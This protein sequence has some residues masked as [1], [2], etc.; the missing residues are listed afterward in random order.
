LETSQLDAVEQA[1]AVAGSARLGLMLLRVQRRRQIQAHLGIVLSER[2][3]GLLCARLRGLLRPQDQVVAAA[4]DTDIVVLLPDLLSPGHAQMAAQR[5]LRE[6]DHPIE[7][8]GHSV[9]L[10]LTI[11]LALAPDHARAGD[12][13]ARAALLALD[14][15][16]RGGERFTMAVAGAATGLR[17]EDLRHALL[18]NELTMAFQPQLDLR[19]G[20]IVAVEALARWDHPELGG[21]APDQF[22]GLAERMGLSIEL[23]RWSLN[24]ALREHAQLR[25]QMPELACAI[26]LSPKIFGQSGLIEQVLGALR[27][28]DLPP[29]LLTVEVTETAVLED[30]DYSGW[31]LAQ[32]HAAGVDISIDDFG[33]GYSSFSYFKQFPARELKIDQLFVTQVEADPRDQQIIRSMIELAHNLGMRALAE[34]VENA[35]VLQLLTE[36]GCDRAQG[37]HIGRPKPVED[38]LEQWGQGT[39]ERVPGGVRAQGGGWCESG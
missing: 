34:G 3:Q 9:L 14:G 29:R 21:I 31:V 2:L 1:L 19:T 37:F 22:I 25:R 30:T 26:N 8:E 36:M 12:A 15:A 23:T 20:Q 17:V 7:I 10:R 38:C 13:L 35:Q 18:Q 16:V 32:L 24:A 28:W 4:L 39:G 33:R 11:G 5:I 6:F 27:V